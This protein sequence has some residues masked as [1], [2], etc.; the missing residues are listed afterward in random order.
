MVS[1]ALEP[2]LV[3]P[4]KC[5]SIWT[6]LDSVND[7]LRIILLLVSILSTMVR[8]QGENKRFSLGFLDSEEDAKMVGES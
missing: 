7:V 4:Y 3:R 8:T 6:S 5:N 2:V 1:R